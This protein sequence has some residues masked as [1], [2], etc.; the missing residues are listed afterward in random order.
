ML[1]QQNYYDKAK[2]IDR[3]TTLIQNRR[4]THSDLEKTPKN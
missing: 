4:L 1:I 3:A 2:K